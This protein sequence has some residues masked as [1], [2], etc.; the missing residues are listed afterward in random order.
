MESR[1]FSGFRHITMIF[2][3]RLAII[4]NIVRSLL[5]REYVKFA[6]NASRNGKKRKERD[7]WQ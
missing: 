6:K 2:R 4:G 3:I 7:K 5:N 1:T